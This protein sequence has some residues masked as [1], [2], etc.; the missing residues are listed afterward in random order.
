MR[1][2]RRGSSSVDGWTLYDPIQEFRRQGV[3]PN[4]TTSKR[5]MTKFRLVDN[6]NFQ[7]SPTYPSRFVVPA[8]FSNNDVKKV[9]R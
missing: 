6:T 1:Q 3:I 7:L 9:V 5:V 2:G 8:L 4:E